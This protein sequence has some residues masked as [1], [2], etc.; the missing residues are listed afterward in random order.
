MP[1][2]HNFPNFKK[3]KTFGHSMEPLLHDGDVVNIKKIDFPRLKINDIVSI[4]KNY[5]FFTH[6]VVFKN[7]KYIITKGDNN[8]LYDGKIYSKN[9]IGIVNKV[10]RNTQIIDIE[11]LYL[12]QSTLYFQEIVKVKKKLEGKKIDHII[13][14]GLPLHLYYEGT[15]PRRLYADCDI[16]IERQKLTKLK[17]VFKQLGY[18]ILDTSYSK[19]LRNLKSEETEISFSKIVNGAIV[20]FDVHLEAVF[21]M[22]QI[23]NINSLYPKKLVKKFTKDLLNEVRYVDILDEKFPILS[24]ENLFIYLIL[25][26]FHHNFAG[27]YRYDLIARIVEK[28][29]LDYSTIIKKLNLYKLNNFIYPVIML[30]IKYYGI[31]FDKSFMSQVIPNKNIL[32]IINHKI[33]N[34]NIFNGENRVESGVKRF[35][36]IYDLSPSGSIKK[37]TILLNLN[38]LL[39]IYWY[40]VK[41]LKYELLKSQKKLLQINN[42]EAKFPQSIIL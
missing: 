26:L 8:N 11:S 12:M 19:T 24:S 39:F 42:S 38:V 13:L 27:T 4:N 7:Q 28:E 25:H 31:K 16:L 40:I 30:L 29:K 6:R 23:P 9:V 34:T 10:Q 2:T 18:S 37:S 36:L 17:K 35:K 15:H 33:A 20:S 32:K 1:V 21:L 22:T 41:R 5:R 3:I 14:K